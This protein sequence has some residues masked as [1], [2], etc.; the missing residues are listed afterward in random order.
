[1]SDVTI[2]LTIEEAECLLN[3][4]YA[5]T[6]ALNE[7]EF[8]PRINQ[9]IDLLRKAVHTALIEKNRNKPV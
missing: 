5:N 2:T 4:L 7:P 6:G 9:F 8:I 1:M 3:T